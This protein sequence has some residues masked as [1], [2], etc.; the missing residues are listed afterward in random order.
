MVGRTVMAN[1][2]IEICERS[3]VVRFKLKFNTDVDVRHVVVMRRRE[4]EI[5]QGDK[6]AVQCSNEKLKTS[7]NNAHARYDPTFDRCCLSVLRTTIISLQQV[8]L[9]FVNI[10][11]YKTIFRLF[12]YNRIKC[13]CCSP[14]CRR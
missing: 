1:P 2:P 8:L 9:H 3:A 10:S 5:I 13:F 4:C 6:S 12:S 14:Y 11:V 7:L